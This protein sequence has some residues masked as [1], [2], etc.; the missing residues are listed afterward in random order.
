MAQQLAEK[1]LTLATLI[2]AQRPRIVNLCAYLT[3]CREA[4]EDLAQETLVEAWRSRNRLADPSGA[5]RWLSVV[6]RNICRRWQRAEGRRARLRNDPN[7]ASEPAPDLDN[8]PS[9]TADVEIELERDELAGLL[10]RA[11]AQLPAG[12]RD[13]L[14]R[15]YILE[16]PQ[17]EIAAR[18]GLSEGAVEARLQRGKLSLRRLLTSDLR[19]EANAYGLCLAPADQW[20]AT[21]LWCPIC[22]QHKLYGQLPNG[23]QDFQLHCPQCSWRPNAYFAQSKRRPEFERVKGF[24]AVLNR[25]MSHMHRY[26]TPG[27][28]GGARAC[29]RCGRPVHLV[30]ELPAH[31]PAYP[32]YSR[33]GVSLKCSACGG[34]S[35]SDIYGLALDTPEGVDFWRAHPR[36]STL[37]EQALEA[38]G[39]AAWRV[40]FESR[41]QA[42]QLNVLLA[43]DSYQVLAVHADHGG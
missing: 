38:D 27:L 13:A 8:V 17:A 10:D 14:I 31:V 30:H 16:M 36:M 7:G 33:R 23:D 19:A 20:Q 4:A 32:G 34:S 29:Q 12:T 3:G 15:K 22:G 9:E 40:R 5:D 37:P 21:R 26:L 43:Q 41:T 24:R 2:E 39:R 35:Y 42:A 1:D 25:F 11:L 28:G 6:T 18:L